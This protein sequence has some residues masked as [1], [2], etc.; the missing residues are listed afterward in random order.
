MP[1]GERTL[2][3]CLFCLSLIPSVL[4]RF[5]ALDSIL[6][7]FVFCQSSKGGIIRSLTT[8]GEKVV[9]SVLV[10]CYLEEAAVLCVAVRGVQSLTATLNY[11]FPP[12][13]DRP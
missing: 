8:A 7:T 12:Y 2:A 9:K 6:D 4:F 5:M 10:W 1:R 13:P 11:V 3:I